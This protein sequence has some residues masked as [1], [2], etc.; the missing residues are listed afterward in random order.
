ML[1]DLKLALRQLRKSPGFAVTAVLTLALGIGVNA[2]VFSVMNAIVLH[3]L[4]VPHAQDLH[5]AERAVS[6]ALVSGL[7]GPARPQPYL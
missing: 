1:D 2:V 4:N 6:F 7:S 5:G 3:P